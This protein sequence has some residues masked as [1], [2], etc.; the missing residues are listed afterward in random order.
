MN[1]LQEML[2]RL[3]SAPGAAG[4][5]DGAAEVA[6]ELLSFLPSV[7]VDTMGSVVASFGRSDAKMHILLDAH[8]DQIGM[9]VTSIDEN[10]FVKVARD[11]RDGPPGTAGKPRS[12]IWQR[13]AQRNCVLSAAPPDQWRR[14]QGAGYYGY[15]CGCGSF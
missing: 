2:F 6:R 8:L 1:Q 7:T 9:L 3:C 12:G 15:G 11:G 14:R 10:G 4:R 13:D 5:E